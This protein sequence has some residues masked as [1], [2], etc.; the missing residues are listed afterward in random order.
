MLNQILTTVAIAAA[1][2]AAHAQPIILDDFEQVQK[3]Q[4]QGSAALTL[5]RAENPGAGGSGSLRATFQ[6]SAASPAQAH[7]WLERALSEPLDLSDVE[8]LSLAYRSEQANPAVALALRLVDGAGTEAFITDRTL[9]GQPAPGWTRRAWPISAMGGNRA[10]I[11]LADVRRVA[12]HVVNHA[13]I[14]DAGSFVFQ[15][16]DLL[17]HPAAGTAREMVLD[18]FEGYT[19]AGEAWQNWSTGETGGVIS[20]AEPHSG[21]HSLAMKQ[22]VL[23]GP[24]EPSVVYTLPSPV[25]L[26]IASYLRISVSGDPALQARNP[27]LRLYVE[28]NVGNRRFAEG[29]QYIASREWSSMLFPFQGVAGTAGMWVEDET[30]GRPTQATNMGRITR[31]GLLVHATDGSREPTMSSVRID[32]LK[33]GFPGS[34]RV[35]DGVGPLQA[36][37]TALNPTPVATVAATPTVPAPIIYWSPANTTVMK[38]IRERRRPVVLFFHRDDVPACITYQRTVLDSEWFRHSAAS[39]ACMIAD[40]RSDALPAAQFRI[41]E[42]PALVILSPSGAMSGPF[43]ATT[44][45]ATI[46]AALAAAAQ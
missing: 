30:D 6:Y 44:D 38:M 27:R 22:F 17:A 8:S 12:L 46:Q 35:P 41:T 19:S 23:D 40:S 1:V 31:I 3:Q 32:D 14:A 39:F 9:T 16:D 10:G 24:R 2:S 15:V 43:T 25:D 45:Q 21:R 26:S 37:P 18:G 33:M 36:T 34:D 11:N 29:S 42:V 4:H 5:E 7:A 20:L 28:D 13:A